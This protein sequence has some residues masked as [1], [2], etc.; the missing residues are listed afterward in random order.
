MAFTFADMKSE[1][2]RRA[3]KNQGGSSFDIGIGNIINTS[4]WRVAREARWRSLRRQTS[5]DTVGTYSTGTGAVTLST[6]SKSVT[7]PSGQLLTNDIKI[8][9]YVKFSNSS[10]YF[11]IA[12]IAGGTSLTLNQFFDGTNTT[13]GSYSILGQEEYVLPIQVGHSAL[14]WHRAYGYPLMMKYIPTMSFYEAGLTDTQE[15]VPIAYRMWGM[16]TNLSEVK[17]PS[18]VTISSSSTADTSIAVTVFGTV[19]DYPD[20]EIIT[21]NSSN[22]TT[23][24]NGA[25]IFSSI[26]RI[27]KNQT[28]AGRITCTT[29][30][31]NTT[32]AILPVGGTTTGP[33]YTKI[34]LYPLPATIFPINVL[35]YKIPFQLVNDGDVPE[36][37][38]EFSEAII[39]LSTA[40]LKAEQNQKEDKDFMAL[41]TDE[42]SSLKRTNVDKLD[43]LPKLKRPNEFNDN[44]TG[45]LR[46]SQIGNSGLYGP[47]SKW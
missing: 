25:K 40:K 21:T 8:G 39:L 6:N 16:N 3:T 24:V 12:T 35:F 13:S 14:L 20:Y 26:E 30:S 34:Q 1:V 15:N 7:V 37:G 17:A 10:T 38:E 45:G 5:F 22:G 47:R 31:A 43:W 46:Y 9:R 36:I 23:S 33:L 4:M 29:N 18:I 2:K 28:T 42:I 32:V 11:K 19:S 44:W 41:Y 27:V